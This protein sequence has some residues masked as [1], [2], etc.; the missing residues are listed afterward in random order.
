MAASL[1]TQILQAAITELALNGSE[2]FRSTQ[3][4]KELHIARSLINHHFGNQ[5]GLIAEATVTAYE[6]YVDLL[7]SAAEEHTAPDDRLEA[8]ITAQT[9]WF[10]EHRGIAVLLQMA[11]PTYSAAMRD[12]FGARMERSF[13]FNM[14]VL[15]TLVLDVERHEVSSL[16]FTRDGAP[17]SVMLT[18]NLGL[19]MRTASVGMSALGSSVWAAGSS[20]PTRD[21]KENYLE[22]VSLAQHAKWVVRSINTTR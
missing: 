7:R 19:L 17:Y 11:H 6:Q 1:R 12:G 22:S 14:T 2:F 16:N 18:Q 5:T 3:L 20:A 15:A 9:H 13:Q 10:G 21:A 8:W 4:C